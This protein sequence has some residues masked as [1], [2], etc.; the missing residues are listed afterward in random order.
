MNL[1]IDYGT[2]VNDK[3]NRVRMGLYECPICK[4][5]FTRNQYEMRRAIKSRNSKAYCL[6][7]TQRDNGSSHRA[8]GTRYHRIWTNMKQRC[9]NPKNKDFRWYG[10]KGVQ[11][12]S[13]WAND[14]ASFYEWATAN[15]YADNL[16]IDRINND[17][18]Y[19][20]DNCRWVTIQKQQK[21][22]SR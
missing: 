8:S 21:N 20:P 17:G 16:T 9:S 19:S 10:A 3:G 2:S 12:C 13:E 15:G 11:V 22:R 4:N 7:C 1:L 6:S 18:D 5:T 14:F